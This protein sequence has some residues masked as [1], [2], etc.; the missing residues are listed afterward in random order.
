MMLSMRTTVTLDPD[1]S[2]LLNE[3]VHRARKPFKQVLNEAVRRGLT[4]SLA[5]KPRHARY[6]VRPHRATFLPG[7]DRHRLNAL[8]D[9]LED[10]A[11]LDGLAARSSDQAH[12]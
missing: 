9:E 2:A 11:V 1:V 8:T 12:P 4:P 6:R 5:A 10:Q 3:E 7:L